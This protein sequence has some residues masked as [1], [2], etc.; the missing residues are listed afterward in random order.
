MVNSKSLFRTLEDVKWKQQIVNIKKVAKP[1]KGGV[2]LSFQAIVVVGDGEGNVGV[3]VGKA[4]D[5]AVAIK[6]A[7]VDGHKNVIN[8]AL[9]KHKSIPYKIKGRFGAAKLVLKPSYI[10]SGIIAGGSPKIVL[11]LAGI[12]NILAKQLGSNNSLNNARATINA[13]I[14][15]RLSR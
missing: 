3:G 5:T 13:L 4:S 6:K 10:G 9:T 7:T 2:N 12:Q 15:I 8:V 1:V 14:D 11:E